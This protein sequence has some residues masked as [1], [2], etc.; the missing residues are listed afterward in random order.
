VQSCELERPERYANLGSDAASVIAR[1]QGAAMA[2]R[3]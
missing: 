2:M 3:H 1:G